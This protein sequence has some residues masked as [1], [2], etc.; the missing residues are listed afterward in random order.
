MIS[1][2]LNLY[3]SAMQTWSCSNVS[4]IVLFRML[5]LLNGISGLFT[6]HA[7]SSNESFIVDE[8]GLTK[9]PAESTLF[10]FD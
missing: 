6:N 8:V 2:K 9:K 4:I 3:L 7:N 1:A 5:Y 10:D